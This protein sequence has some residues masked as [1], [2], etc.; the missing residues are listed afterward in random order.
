MKKK[1]FT[2]LALLLTAATGAWALPGE[3][4]AYVP[5]GLYF[6]VSGTSVTL[7]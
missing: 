5:S 3:E 4:T 1:I 2:L 7:K 6:E